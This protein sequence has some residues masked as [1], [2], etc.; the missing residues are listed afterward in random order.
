MPTGFRVE[1]GSA[2]SPKLLPLAPRLASLLF[3]LRENGT[4]TPACPITASRIKA[5]MLDA[6]ISV[7]NSEV[8]AMVNHLR[9]A[10]H[11]IASTGDGYF[12]A[13]TREELDST[14]QHMQERI[15]SMRDAVNGMLRSF[16][17]SQTEL[18]FR[19]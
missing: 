4:V 15:A 2:L 11:P 14:V 16:Q 10:G 6:G 17:N 5:R 7:H 19:T 9:R 12:W 13:Q 8:C 18:P 3:R 1:T